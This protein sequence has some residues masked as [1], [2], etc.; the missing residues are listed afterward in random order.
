VEQGIITHDPRE[1]AGPCAVA[2]LQ[3]SPAFEAVRHLF[4]AE[5]QLWLPLREAETGSPAAAELCAKLAAIQRQVLG[6]G[7]RLIRVENEQVYEV[8]EIH[9]EGLKVFWK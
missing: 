5:V 1:D 2:W 4:D 3:P 6:P 9:I 7:V 8:E